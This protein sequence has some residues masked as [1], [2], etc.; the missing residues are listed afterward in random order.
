MVTYPTI[1]DYYKCSD[2]STRLEKVE[3]ILDGLY[4]AAVS[5][6]SN[7]HIE[8]YRLDDGQIIIK[9][10]Y[11]KMDDLSKAIEKFETIRNMLINRDCIGNSIKLR[12]QDSFLI[13]RV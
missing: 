10:I 2:S 1:Y 5:F 6:A 4:D 13:N 3:T 8:E 9:T 7:S 11:R 12:D